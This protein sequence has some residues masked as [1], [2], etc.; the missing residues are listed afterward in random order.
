[1]FMAMISEKE[2]EILDKMLPLFKDG[3]L[4]AFNTGGIGVDEDEFW[5][6]GDA[7]IALKPRIFN[8]SRDG[9]ILLAQGDLSAFMKGGGFRGIYKSQ[10]KAE[11]NKKWGKRYPILINL[12]MLI[13]TII[14]VYH[15]VTVSQE[16]QQD[17]TELR[18]KIQLRLS[19]FD[20]RLLRLQDTL[21]SIR[22]PED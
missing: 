16:Q 21:S 5:E 10:R 19:D 6:Y 11:A 9:N 20:N 13:I 8:K 7:A 17:L 14:S 12:G 1:M 3:E 18:E 22:A 15:A 4:P 2:A